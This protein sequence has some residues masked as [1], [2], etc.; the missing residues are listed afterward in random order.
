MRQV[1]PD[2][3]SDLNG[4]RRPGSLPF[5]PKE[6]AMLMPFAFAI[7]TMIAVLGFQT[8]LKLVNGPVLLRSR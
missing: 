5:G 8:L 7:A 2:G 3:S 4:P 6:F 1:I